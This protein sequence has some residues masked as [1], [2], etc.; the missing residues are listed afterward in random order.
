MGKLRPRDLNSRTRKWP[1][2]Y[3]NIVHSLGT[4]RSTPGR[5]RL[6]LR[7]SCS[8]RCKVA[9]HSG[10]AMKCRL[11]RVSGWFGSVLFLITEAISCRPERSCDVKL[12]DR[13]HFFFLVCFCPSSLLNSIKLI[14]FRLS[15]ER[16]QPNWSQ[17]DIFSLSL[18]CYFVF[19]DNFHA[20]LIFP[21]RYHNWTEA[22]ITSRSTSFAKRILYKQ[23][24]DTITT[25][26]ASHETTIKDPFE[27]KGGLSLVWTVIRSMP[28]VEKNTHFLSH[29]KGKERWF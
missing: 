1:Q 25:N 12:I 27:A 6:C 5:G 28:T 15:K 23:S 18:T 9:L 19:R 16:N 4:T 7:A 14:S 22:L 11:F 24:L 17:S 13:K 26:Q 2:N 10:I 29:N 21:P 3:G 8:S 20:I